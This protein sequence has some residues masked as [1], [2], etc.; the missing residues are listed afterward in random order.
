[1]IYFNK[2]SHLSPRGDGQS[3]AITYEGKNKNKKVANRKDTCDNL[4]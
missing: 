2:K 1:M 4:R 3:A